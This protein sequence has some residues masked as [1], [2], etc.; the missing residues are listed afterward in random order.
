MRILAIFVACVAAS[1]IAAASP[2]TK[3]SLVG[4]MVDMLLLTRFPTPGYKTIQFSSYDRT[5]ASA[6]LPVS[7][8]TL[9][10]HTERF[11]SHVREFG[12]IHAQSLGADHW[13]SS[14]LYSNARIRRNGDH[15][16][17]TGIGFQR[18]EGLGPNS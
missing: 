17:L 6:F 1:G 9:V 5:L 4:E 10:S 2:I 18:T 7:T 16:L 13:G 15:G 12:Y 3:G 8:V 14:I 11:P